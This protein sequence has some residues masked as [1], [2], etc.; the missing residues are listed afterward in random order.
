MRTVVVTFAIL[1]CVATGVAGDVEDGLPR[2]ANLPDV[3]TASYGS[4]PG[5][6]DL[7]GELVPCE[8]YGFANQLFPVAVGLSC[9]V[10]L[11]DALLNA[12]ANP[13]GAL[14]PYIYYTLG[15]FMDPVT[16][17]TIC[18]EGCFKLR[19][20]E[21]A[22]APIVDSPAGFFSPAPS[23]GGYIR[24]PAPLSSPMPSFSAQAPAPSGPSPVGSPMPSYL[25][26][27]PVT[28]GPAPYG[29]PM[30]SYPVQGPSTSVSLPEGS[31]I[32]SPDDH[33]PRS[34]SPAPYYPAPEYAPPP[35]SGW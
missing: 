21:P 3:P 16:G 23:P 24:G 30:A 28:G 10:Q 29:S 33:A 2:P 9:L 18:Y 19:S 7:Q 32:S 6:L 26:R 34:S 5:V 14:N 11:R 15:R 20:S 17:E 25:A 8:W 35:E 31:P 13:P 12:T 27:G 1:A 4:L 22:A